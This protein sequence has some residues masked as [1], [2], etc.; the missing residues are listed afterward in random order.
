MENNEV[1]NTTVVEKPKK[2]KKEINLW[3][4]LLIILCVGLAIVGGFYFYCKSINAKDNDK[5]EVTETKKPEKTTTPTNI[6]EVEVKE[7]TLAVTDPVVQKLYS[8]V[9]NKDYKTHNM[10]QS[11]LVNKVATK[12]SAN[13]LKPEE[14][15][16][17]GFR[18]M[19]T[20]N[21]KLVQCS[22]YPSVLA[23]NQPEDYLS[24][25][26]VCSDTRDLD[27]NFNKT[28]NK[29]DDRN[30]WTKAI[31]ES[32]LKAKVEAIFG[33]NT[34]QANNF[35]IDYSNSFIYDNKTG[36]YVKMVCTQ[37]GGTNGPW[38]VSTLTSAKKT[39]NAIE[40]LELLT[41]NPDDNTCA[42]NHRISIR[43][44]FKHVD[45]NYYY[46][47]SELAN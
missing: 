19:E 21:I 2:L 34:Y 28:F 33:T 42:A 32:L 29:Y 27:S 7:E 39:A 36:E 13:T 10:I 20:G 37:C 25:A 15:N 14:K 35:Q 6:P 23:Y 24:Y 41:C 12:I 3:L 45:G 5:K 4:G 30:N 46:D 11:V 1:K 18:Q 44:V 43:H 17:L 22:N 26:Y 40:I 38:D 31:S 47:Y 8:Y 16:Y 9:D